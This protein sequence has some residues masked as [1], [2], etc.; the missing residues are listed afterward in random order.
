MGTHGQYRGFEEIPGV[1]RYANISD[2]CGANHRLAP[3]YKEM[4]SPYHQEPKL[5]GKWCANPE[6]N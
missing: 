3:R 1:R 4:T 6:I 5:F 2:P